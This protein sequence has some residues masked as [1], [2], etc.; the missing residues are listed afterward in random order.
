MFFSAGNLC[1]SVI[2]PNGKSRVSAAN[3]RNSKRQQVEPRHSIRT[4]AVTVGNGNSNKK[5]PTIRLLAGNCIEYSGLSSRTISVPH[6]KPL[7][8]KLETKSKFCKN[9]KNISIHCEVQIGETLLFACSA[10][11]RKIIGQ[12]ATSEAGEFKSSISS[13]PYASLTSGEETKSSSQSVPASVEEYSATIDSSDADSTNTN[14]FQIDPLEV[15]QSSFWFTDKDINMEAELD[16]KCDFLSVIDPLAVLC[17]ADKSYNA[18]LKLPDNALTSDTLFC[19]LNIDNS[20]SVMAVYSKTSQ[21]SHFVN[22]KLN[23]IFNS[24]AQLDRVNFD[25]ISYILQD[26]SNNRV[27]FICT[28]AATISKFCSRNSVSKE[29]IRLVRDAKGKVVFYKKRQQQSGTHDPN[30]V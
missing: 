8:R 19:L 27:P 5:I 7:P 18:K 26:N 28:Y 6:E 10:C 9:C 14:F 2:Y 13:I 3:N 30:S 24:S 20:H 21:L 15:D 12:S 16:T 17:F 23:K 25:K 4:A 29:I 22:S 1:L 11:L